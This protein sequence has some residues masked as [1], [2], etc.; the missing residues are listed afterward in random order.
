MDSKERKN[1]LVTCGPGL[2]DYLQ[3]ELEGLGV[4]KLC[5][6]CHIVDR[7]ILMRYHFYI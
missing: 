5:I 6:L 4:V 3:A 2:K 7:G 1:I